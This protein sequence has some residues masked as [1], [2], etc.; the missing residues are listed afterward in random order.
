MQHN[1]AWVLC[2]LTKA[3]EEGEELITNRQKLIKVA[4]RSE[5]GWATVEEYVADELADNSDDEKRL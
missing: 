4:D 3:L 5:F 2:P 1:Q